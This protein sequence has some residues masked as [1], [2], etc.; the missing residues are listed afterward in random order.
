VR[1]LKRYLLAMLLACLVLVATAAPA[2]AVG[3]PGIGGTPPGF[4]ER[5]DK[6]TFNPSSDNRTTPETGGIRY[7]ECGDQPAPFCQPG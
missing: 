4:G 6:G 7:G 2:F 5:N 3:R 1:D